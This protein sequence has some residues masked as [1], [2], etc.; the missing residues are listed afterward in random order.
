MAGEGPSLESLCQIA[1]VVKDI[2]A[3]ARRWAEVFS[4]P[5]PEARLTD[6]ADKTNIRYHGEP[7][8]AQGEAGVL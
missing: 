4:V 1:I 6:A 5:V 3:A 7:T 8:E 2:E